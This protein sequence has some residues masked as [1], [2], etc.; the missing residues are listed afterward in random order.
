M[1]TTTLK[2]RSHISCIVDC[3]EFL[4]KVPSSYSRRHTL[5]MPPK[6]DCPSMEKDISVLILYRF[7]DGQF[8]S[9]ESLCH[10][11][12]ELRSANSVGDL[13]GPGW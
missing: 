8:C 10:E 6:V 9:D 1:L 4:Q 12:L 2:I 3:G 13:H 11:V 7:A 5:E